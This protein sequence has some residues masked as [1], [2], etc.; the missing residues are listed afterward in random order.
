MFNNKKIKALE[1]RIAA[2]EREA[3]E[4]RPVS[5]TFSAPNCNS[6]D[7]IKEHNKIAKA[8]RFCT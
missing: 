7:L 3:Q 8:R 2:L 6:D 4:R 1:K 5:F